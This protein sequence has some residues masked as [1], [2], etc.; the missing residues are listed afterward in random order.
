MLWYQLSIAREFK[1]LSIVPFDMDTIVVEKG[2]VA[3]FMVVVLDGTLK[4]ERVDGSTQRFDEGSVLCLEGLTRPFAKG[5]K[6]A[7][8]RDFTLKGGAGGGVIGIMLYSEMVRAALFD[9][10]V[11]K[12]LLAI[13]A[14]QIE[15]CRCWVRPEGLCQ[16]RYAQSGSLATPL[17]F[18]TKEVGAVEDF[19]ELVGASS[20]RIG[21]AHPWLRSPTP[22]W[23]L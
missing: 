12:I 22:H 5:E 15:E 21:R 13:R 16:L 6:P 14:L 8:T 18:V 7:F 3:T 20:R 2:E 17:C 10:E 1:V 11:V 19:G 9:T 4:Q 23:R